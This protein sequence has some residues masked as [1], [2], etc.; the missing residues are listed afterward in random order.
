MFKKGDRVVIMLTDRYTLNANILE[1]NNI[2]VYVSTDDY[3]DGMNCFYPFSSIRNI[4][5]KRGE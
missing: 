3:G 5:I 4:A 1:I 2:G